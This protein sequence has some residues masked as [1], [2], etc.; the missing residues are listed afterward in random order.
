[1]SGTNIETMR[2][3]LMDTLADLRNPEKPM[4]VDRARAIAQVASALIDSARVEVEFLK[5]IGDELA[6]GTGF[7]PMF[8]KASGGS[9]NPNPGQGS[10]AEPAPPG[11]G[12]PLPKGV[13]GVTQ[14]R[15]R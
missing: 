6:Q 2:K 12:K 3:H 8:P 4:E 1:M 15:L 10:G 5:T 7:I 14:H 9:W 13:L 11:D